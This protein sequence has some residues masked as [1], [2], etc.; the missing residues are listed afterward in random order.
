MRTSSPR[1]EKYLLL[2]LF[3]FFA[4]RFCLE[5]VNKTYESM[6]VAVTQ[7]KYATLQ[8]TTIHFQKSII[9]FEKVHYKKCSAIVETLKTPV[10]GF[11][12]H[13]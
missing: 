1:N 8:F 5:I 3:D 2:N 10:Q 11:Q 7:E 13:E 9:K 12:I 6:K 4:E